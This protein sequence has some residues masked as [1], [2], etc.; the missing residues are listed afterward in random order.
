MDYNSFF[1]ELSDSENLA[2]YL[3]TEDYCEV[4][5]S[6]ARDM[7]DLL[8][9]LPDYAKS[10]LEMFRIK[11]HGIKG[12]TRQVGLAA[13]SQYADAMQLAAKASDID[14][15]NE[16]L[17]AFLEEMAATRDAILSKIAELT[18]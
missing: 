6:I 11:T 8:T 2:N 15:V 12:V 7:E 9:S 14:Y 13:F 3:S 18:S 4:L 10:D 17:P 5:H 16:N 1:T